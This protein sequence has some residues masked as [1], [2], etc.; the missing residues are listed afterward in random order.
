MRRL[1]GLDVLD[2][3][4]SAEWFHAVQMLCS[5]E[6]PQTSQGQLCMMM[7]NTAILYI[8]GNSL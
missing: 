6:K 1:T 7:L 8:K 4:Q 5:H 3:I 2:V